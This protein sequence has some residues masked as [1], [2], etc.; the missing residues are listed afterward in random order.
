MI[1]LEPIAGAV[2]VPEELET[3]MYYMEQAIRQTIRNVDVV[4]RY[5]RQ[6]LLVILLG[7]D[8]EGVRTAM[9]RI[10]RGYYKM[11]GSS[12]FSPSYSVADPRENAM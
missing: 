5:S 2:P 3:S 6:Q 7:T 8:R 1:K 12:A 4:T 11:N 10:F 9:E